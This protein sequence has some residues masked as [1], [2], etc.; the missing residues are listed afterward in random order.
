MSSAEF[1]LWMGLQL[2]RQDEC[3]ECGVEP[4]DLMEFETVKFHCPV[5]NHDSFRVKRI[6]KVNF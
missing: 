6:G 4:K 1:E 2:L 5:C 3:P